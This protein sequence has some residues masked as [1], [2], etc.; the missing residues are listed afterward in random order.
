MEVSVTPVAVAPDALPGPQTWPRLPNEPAPP[1][2]ESLEEE[3]E[4]EDDDNEDG[5]VELPAAVLE[6]DGGDA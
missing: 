6:V 1:P 4:E 5:S 3:E 2:A